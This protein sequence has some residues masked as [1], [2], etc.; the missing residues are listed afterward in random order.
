[1]SLY[2]RYKPALTTAC[3]RATKKWSQ[4]SD[5]NRQTLFSVFSVPNLRE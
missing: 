3:R 2:V 5:L 4:L 1:M